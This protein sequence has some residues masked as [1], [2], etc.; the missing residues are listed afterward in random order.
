MKNCTVAHVGD[1]FGSLCRPVRRSG[2]RQF[3]T[4]TR[5]RWPNDQTPSATVRLRLGADLYLCKLELMSTRAVIS[6]AH[7]MYHAISLL[8]IVISLRGVCI[9]LM[10]LFNALMW[11]TFVKSFQKCSSTVQATVTNSAANFFFSV[12]SFCACTTLL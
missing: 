4:S 2:L 5:T 6:H 3:Q 8:Q 7:F 11:T 12:R 10:V 9:V 1:S